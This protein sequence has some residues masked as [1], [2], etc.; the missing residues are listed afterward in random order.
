MAAPIRTGI[1]KLPAP[2]LAYM[3]VLPRRTR[4]SVSGRVRKRTGGGP[5]F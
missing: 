5:G 3:A 2:I 4:C 1:G